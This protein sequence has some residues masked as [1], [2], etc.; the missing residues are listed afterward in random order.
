MPA[1]KPLKTGVA[2]SVQLMPS[3]ENSRHAPPGGIAV[4]LIEPSVPLQVVGSLPIAL[5]TAPTGKVLTLISS[6]SVETRP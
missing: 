6:L 1:G 5:V 2:L 4:T 3:I